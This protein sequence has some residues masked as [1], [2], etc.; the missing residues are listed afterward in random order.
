M[1]GSPFTPAVNV[2]IAIPLPLPACC[3]S[4]VLKLARDVRTLRSLIRRVDP[5]LVVVVTTLV[6]A[7]LIAA[8]LEGLPVI[9]HAAELYGEHYAHTR[10][11]ALAA[12]AVI[13]L[14]ARLANSSSRR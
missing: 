5:D 9:V 3:G 7:A 4:G 1:E 13:E 11:R 2:E 10:R 14:N 12:R 6:P 8:R